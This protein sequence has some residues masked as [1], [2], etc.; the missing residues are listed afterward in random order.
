MRFGKTLQ[1]LGKTLQTLG[2]T[3]Q[4]LGKTL[5]PLLIKPFIIKGFRG[6][7]VRPTLLLF[8]YSRISK[9]K[10]C[11]TP[12]LMARLKQSTE[13]CLEKGYY[14]Y[15]LLQLITLTFYNKKITYNFPNTVQQGGRTLS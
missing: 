14:P 15:N 3:L 8:Y 13:E 6:F 7:L 12:R 9:E 11:F 1:N 10:D 2:K 4:N 5:H